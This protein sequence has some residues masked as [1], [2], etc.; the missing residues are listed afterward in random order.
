MSDDEADEE[1]LDLLRKSLGMTSGKAEPPK[2]QVL[3]DAEFINDNATDVALDMQ[4]TKAAAERIYQS[5]Q[6]KSYDTHIWRTHELHPQSKDSNT[7]HFIFVMDLLNF[8]FWSSCED[9]SLRYVVEYRE[10]Q[11]TG[12]RS[13]VAAL[14]R[15]LDDDVP[16]TTPSFWAALEQCSDA[17]LKHVFR[18]STTESMPLLEDRI[19]CLRE[20]GQVLE[21][22]CRT[23]MTLNGQADRGQHFGGTFVNVL[24]KANGS[25]AALVDLL[26]RN[27]PSFDDSHMFEDR[28]V[29]FYKR[30]QILVADIWACFEGEGYGY[31][32]DIDQVT[33]FAGIRPLTAQADSSC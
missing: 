27:F 33:M 8:S 16:I 29:R 2:I 12:Y 23:T 18:S 6:E 17:N 20:A 24:E 32:A 26:V 5:M 9:S 10:K 30:A 14:Q 25:A 3:E 19:S 28:R 21:D 11:W 7:V 15:A 13:L 31:F 22:V 4:G 1:L